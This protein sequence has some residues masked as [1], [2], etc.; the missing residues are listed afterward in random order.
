MPDLL[1]IEH[2]SAGYG[3]AHVLH[4]VSLSL[5][6]GQALALLGRNGVGKSTLINTIVGHTRLFGGHIRLGGVELTELRPHR[7]VAIGVG[8]VPQERSIFPSLTVEENLTAVARP[9]QWTPER[10][11]GLFPRLR[12]RARNWGD[13]LSGGEQQM[14]AVARALVTSPRLLLLDEP[15]EGLAPVIVQELLAAI[16]HL[17]RAEG[18]TVIIVEQNAQ[19]MLRLTDR[20]VLLERGQVVYDG[21]SADLANNAAIIERYIGLGGGARLPHPRLHPHP[22]PATDAPPSSG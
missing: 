20:A 10:A 9:G 8:W 22:S 21:L 18:M 14:L 1:E 16:E 2:V 13:Q 5:A 17:I 11:F 12:E 4:D 19:K 3:G 6:E 7:R 15:L